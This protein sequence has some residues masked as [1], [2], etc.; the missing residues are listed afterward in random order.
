MPVYHLGTNATQLWVLGKGSMARST[1]FITGYETRKEIED[2]YWYSYQE[3]DGKGILRVY[4][5]EELIFEHEAKFEDAFEAIEKTNTLF[6]TAMM[7]PR[8]K[9]DTIAWLLGF[10]KRERASSCEEYRNLLNEK[11]ANLPVIRCVE[12][13]A[14]AVRFEFVKYVLLD[15]EDNSY[16]NLVCWVDEEITKKEILHLIPQ[17]VYP[18]FY[19]KKVLWEKFGISSEEVEKALS[20]NSQF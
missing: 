13:T 8:R 12:Y 7:P 6:V 14:A 18:K 19:V 1:I 4:K 15:E 5:Q 20:F 9:G 17:F 2:D 3:E 16:H 10:S 11:W